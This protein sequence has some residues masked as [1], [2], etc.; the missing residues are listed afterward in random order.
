MDDFIEWCVAIAITLL[1]MVL[2]IGGLVLYYS[3]AFYT[4]W[5]WFVAP[6]GVQE[7]NMWHAYGIM[8]F[9]GLFTNK[10][11]GD[12]STKSKSE[13]IK[14]FINQ[15]SIPAISVFIGWLIKSYI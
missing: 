7:I 5:N 9:L 13:T 12:Y 14:A 6:L 8:M 4:L 10:Y 15:L 11:T 2:I 3:W 1:A